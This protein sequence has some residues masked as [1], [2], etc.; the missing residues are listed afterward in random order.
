MNDP[1]IPITLSW[2]EWGMIL[3]PLYIV[4]VLWMRW[5][6]QSIKPSAPKRKTKGDPA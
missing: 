3:V 2:E 1:L 5:C 4:L 6:M